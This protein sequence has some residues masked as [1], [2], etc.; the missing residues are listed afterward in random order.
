MLLNRR[1][2][3]RNQFVKVFARNVRDFILCEHI[4]KNNR[5]VSGKK[6]IN[7]ACSAALSFPMQRY[8]YL[9]KS[10]T[11]GNNVSRIGANIQNLL[12]FVNFVPRV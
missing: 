1:I 7:D 3:N 6:V 10:V 2:S 4:H 9:S 5:V 8:A 11:A 12:Q